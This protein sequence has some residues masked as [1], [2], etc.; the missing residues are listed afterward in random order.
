MRENSLKAFVNNLVRDKGSLN[1]GRWRK[2]ENLR[3][4]KKVYFLA[5]ESRL[6][7]G[8]EDR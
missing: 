4:V 7:E 1:E 2:V 6:D 8:R 5:L 3:D